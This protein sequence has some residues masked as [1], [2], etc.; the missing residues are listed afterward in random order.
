AYNRTDTDLTGSIATPPV[1]AGLANV[2]F[3]REQTQRVTC[4]QPR[5]NVR[6]TADW[7]R[8]GFGALV[9]GSRYGEYCF[10]TNVV[11]NDQ[12]FG[13]EFLADVEL[14]WRR[15]HYTVGLGVQN[16]FDNFPD[17][18]R[19]VNS[20]FLVQTFPSI[21]PFGFNGRFVYARMAYRF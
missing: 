9:R 21:S 16:L 17:Q 12:T 2:L 13:A 11:A 20:S 4:A 3:D 5:D 6:L 19:T 7:Q 14:T 18:L 1:L 8:G 15:D 10:P